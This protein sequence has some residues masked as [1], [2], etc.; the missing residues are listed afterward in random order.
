VTI[1]RSTAET[2][3]AADPLAR[4]RS[5]F[6]VDDDGPIY[7]DGNSLGPLPGVVPAI[8][9]RVVRQQW[10][11]GLVESWEHWVDLP[12]RIG[13]IVA[14]LIGVDPAAVTIS[15]STSVNLYKLASAALGAHPGRTDVVMVRGEF[16]TDRYLMEAVAAARGGVV[17]TA[18]VGA[19]D[20]P[21]AG[22][23]APLLDER[24][25]LVSLS[26]VSYRSAAIADMAGITAAAHGAG[27]M[28]LWDLSHAVGSIPVDLGAIGADLAVGCTYKYLSGGP[29]APAFLHVRPDLQAGLDHPIHGWFGHARQF[30]FE[31]G[32]EPADGID[33]FVVGTPPILSLAA[34][35]PG[36]ALVAEAGIESI[37][38][39]SV[40]ATT[41]LIDLW[42]HSLA[43]LGFGLASPRDPSRRGSH[44]ALT[45]PDG[46]A[47]SRALREGRRVITDFRAPDAIRLAVSPLVTRFTE[48]WDAVE[49][50]REV[51]VGGYGPPGGHRVT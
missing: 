3:D 12:A 7:L 40:A 9:E 36:I 1:D 35:E 25:A 20:P 45:H 26:A 42:E 17:R 13:A 44:V 39:K 5:Q 15:D 29:G 32:Y 37:R 19:V 2:L 11:A 41:L 33:R 24:V 14:G 49:A 6:V 30:A 21:T 47:I 4:F 31:D 28:V 27:A 18:P 16:P 48:V 43:P 38:A 10:G 8:V 23:I 50:I 34:A 46:L 51:A 22:D